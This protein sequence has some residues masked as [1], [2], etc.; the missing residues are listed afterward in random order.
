MVRQV[1]PIAEGFKPFGPAWWKSMGEAVIQLTK[2]LAE[3]GIG[4]QGPWKPYSTKR[5]LKASQNTGYD[6][7]AEAKAAG[8]FPRQSSTQISPPNLELTG[9]MWRD[10]KTITF[11]ADGVTVGFVTQAE[12]AQFNHEAGR[13]I[14]GPAGPAEPARRL[15]RTAVRDMMRKQLNSTRGVKVIRVGK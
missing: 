5:S 11:E 4:A 10:L 9:D 14:F 7:Y 6:T 13:P 12:R 8:A 1:K 15:I 3:K 2:A